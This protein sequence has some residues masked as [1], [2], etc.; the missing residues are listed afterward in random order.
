MR[1]NRYFEWGFQVTLHEI[2]HALGLRHSEKDGAIM[3]PIY[4][5]K[6]SDSLALTD[7]DI[8]GIRALYLGNSRAANKFNQKV[9]KIK[10]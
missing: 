1:G 10:P 5:R 9:Q 3:H 7:D 4:R 2:G 6:D 8:R